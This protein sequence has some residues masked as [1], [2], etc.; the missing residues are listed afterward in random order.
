MMK[1][2]NHWFFVVAALATLVSC[3]TTAEVKY[4]FYFIGDGTGI[5]QVY[6]T[7]NFNAATGLDPVNFTTFPVHSF[8]TTRSSS[9][10]V[11][12][13]AA[14][15]TALATGHKTYNDAIGVDADVQPVS[16]LVEW[17]HANGCGT[18]VC[19]TVGVN[20]ATPA[21]FYAHTERRGNYE[22]I[23][24]QYLSAPV[25]FAAGGGFIKQRGSDK[26]N[27]YFIQA[28]EEAGIRVLRGPDFR[29]VADTDGRVLCLS[30]KDEDDVPY[31]IDRKE[32][33]TQLCDFVQ[34]GIDY[35]EARFG[36]KGFFFMIEGGKID[37]AG[38]GNDAA[39]LVHEVNDMAAAVDLALAFCER[40]PD[41][42][43]IVITADH[44]TGGLMLGSGK[45][46]M[47]PELLLNQKA[48]KPVL[49][50]KFRETFFPEGA[51]RVAPDW[52]Q[53]KEFFRENLGLWEAV[54]INEQAEAKLR[55]V[56]DDTLG[57]G[58]DLGEANMYAVNSA[59]VVAAVDLLNHAAGYKF[60]FGS[61]SG[62]PVGLYVQ[63]KGWER[64]TD[65][66]DNTE[67]APLIAE[68]AGYK[69]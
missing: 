20:H 25:D 15:G 18:G 44:E 53:V 19:T 56:Y 47:K 2:L 69:H 50:E 67:I 45:Y 66:K 49:T 23:S 14:G 41:E 60:S 55:G 27:A 11:T 16:S 21:S 24:T 30:G 63:G 42:T 33:D 59:L 5:N 51:R 22:D 57:K 39:T 36:D 6:G 17:A 58:R 1:K 10:W 40:H 35:L 64:F 38:H 3:K 52:L 48:S 4:V 13:S 32:D 37:Y 12:D 9:S 28:S 54:P 34:A 43:L 68:L 7:Q 31:A 29:G 26:D 61:H 65:V 62:S 8:I 46:E